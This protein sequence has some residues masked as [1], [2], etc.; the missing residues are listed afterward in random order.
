MATHAQPH[1][2]TLM[3]FCLIVKYLT[4]ATVCCNPTTSAVGTCSIITLGLGGSEGGVG[5]FFCA[6]RDDNS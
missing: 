1:V 6:G 5:V 3:M 2:C 4:V